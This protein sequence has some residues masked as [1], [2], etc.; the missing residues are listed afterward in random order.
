MLMTDW[1]ST[2][3]K[4]VTLNEWV[5]PVIVLSL[6]VPTLTILCKHWN[7]CSIPW[8]HISF[9]SFCRWNTSLNI[10]MIG[11][12]RLL[13]GT[14]VVEWWAEFSV[15]IH[16][17]AKCVGRRLVSGSFSFREQDQTNHESYNWCNDVKK[18]NCWAEKDPA[19]RLL[20]LKSSETS[21]V[22]VKPCSFSSAVTQQVAIIFLCDQTGCISG[23]KSTTSEYLNIIAVMSFNLTNMNLR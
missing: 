17:E 7:L 19:Q 18:K 16:V 5:R 14:T 23:Q 4:S 12:S 1:S 9:K 22:L 8:C 10:A 11:S 15:Y 21:H 2:I 13:V 20:A 6:R 3:N